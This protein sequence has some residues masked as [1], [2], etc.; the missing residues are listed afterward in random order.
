LKLPKCGIMKLTS[1]YSG[2][3]FSATTA[4]PI[5]SITTGSRK[6][7]AA[8]HTSRVGMASLGAWIRSA[9]AESHQDVGTPRACWKMILLNG[10]VLRAGLA[11]AL[12]GGLVG[13]L[14]RGGSAFIKHYALRLV[15]WLNGYTP[16][17]L[18]YVS[19]PLCQADSPE[20]SRRWLYLHPP[21]AAR[22]LCRPN[23]R[24]CD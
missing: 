5:I 9:K 8:S 13:G 1:G 11:Y 12:L 3:N 17:Q 7:R 14:N 23:H 4:R 2:A 16:T 24:D 10:A 21:D 22:I 18:H 15:L 6:A 20:E 19:R